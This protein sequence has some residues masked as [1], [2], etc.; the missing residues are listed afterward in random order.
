MFKVVD[1]IY[2]SIRAKG[3]YC[4]I[5]EVGKIIRAEKGSLGLMIFKEIE[6]AIK[7]TKCTYYQLSRI[8]EV[9][10]IGKISVPKRVS[11]SGSEWWINYF[12]EYPWKKDLHVSPPP[13]TICVP[14]LK[15]IRELEEPYLE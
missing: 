9:K 3:R 5:Y 2:K 8:L 12:N 7:F 6:E 13:G 1:V 15:V 14:S 11:N 10:P 4:R